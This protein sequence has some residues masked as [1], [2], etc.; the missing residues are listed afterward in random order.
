M[1]PLLDIKS[2]KLRKPSEEELREVI[3]SLLQLVPLG[4]VVSYRDLSRVVGVATHLVIRVL[5]ENPNPVVIP[6]HRVVRSDGRVSGYTIRGTR[7]DEL[8]VRLLKLEGV[9][10]VNGRVPKDCF[11]NLVEVLT[12]I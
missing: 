9:R 4:R 12:H 2:G 11:Y 1:L 10:V 7:R 8:K 3:L 6:C 5:K